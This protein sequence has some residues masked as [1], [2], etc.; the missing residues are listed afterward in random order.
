MA[1]MPAPVPQ[2]KRLSLRDAIDLAMS[3]GLAMESA[4]VAV[5][6]A[7]A[8][9][10]SQRVPVNPQFYIAGLNNTV[11]SSHLGDGSNYDIVVTL[12]TN[13]AIQ[14]RSREAESQFLGAKADAQTTKI[15]VL[16][17]VQDAY[18]NLQI[19]NDLLVNEQAIY[20]SI[21]DVAELTQQQ[22]ELGAASETNAIRA[23]V[24]L[25]EEERNLLAAA[26]AVH[27]ARSAFNLQLSRPADEPVD[28]AEPLTFGAYHPSLDQLKVLAEQSRPE[29]SSAKL[30]LDS[31]KAAVGLT[32]SQLYPQLFLG[33]DF[34]QVKAGGFQVGLAMPLFDLGS[35]RGAVQKAQKDVRAQE[36]QIEQVKLG[37]V[38]DVVAAVDA[39]ELSKRTVEALRDGTLPRAEM[40]RA[41]VRE[42][43]KLGASTILDVIDAENT[44]RAVRNEYS[45]ALGDYNH[46]LN[47]LERA[48]G[49]SL[50]ASDA[51]PEI[52]DGG[53]R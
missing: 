13:G 35:I 49:R 16:Q 18:V 32:R 43:Y 29:L 25:T 51:R 23:K 45:S 34:S 20:Q 36:L 47:Q 53:K 5:D 44:Y 52:R 9:F 50:P 41:K 28:V 14:W 4:R 1:L 11:A 22:F 12:E 27:Q 17:G 6:G 3:K 24:A 7:R 10:Q 46:A 26:S 21:A 15:G 31:L 37:I 38:S 48:L 8:N 19:A 40:L 30:G 42:G 2:N 33:T 39:L